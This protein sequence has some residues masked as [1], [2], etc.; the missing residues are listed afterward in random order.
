MKTSVIGTGVQTDHREWHRDGA[1]RNLARYLRG[2]WEGQVT[3]LVPGPGGGSGP[4][5][6]LQPPTT[7]TSSQWHTQ[8][9]NDAY[10][11]TPGD[12]W[13]PIAFSLRHTWEVTMGA[14]GADRKSRCRTLNAPGT[15][16]ASRYLCHIWNTPVADNV[17]AGDASRSLDH[18][19]L[20]H[21][22]SAM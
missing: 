17:P 11:P 3:H 2:S 6:L 15:G 7:E 19:H 12:T 18:T 20:T 10:R 5:L 13:R 4:E 14:P 22:S 9:V 21:L 8:T 16:D 1:L